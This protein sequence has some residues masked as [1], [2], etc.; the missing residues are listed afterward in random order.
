MNRVRTHSFVVCVA[1]LSL[2][3]SAFAQI[4]PSPSADTGPYSDSVYNEGP[5]FHLGNSSLVLHPGL[6]ADFGYDS[7][8]FYLPSNDIGS[9]LMRLRAH[10][11]IA[12]LPPQA[13][14]YDRR[15][16]MPKLDFRFGTQAE[17]REYMT[18]NE[19]VRAQRSI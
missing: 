13:F 5:G 7:N 9:G 6:A 18:S 11:D 4:A 8:V 1:L 15:T 17:Y 3:P 16:E 19:T 12:T 2:A 14:E 10:I